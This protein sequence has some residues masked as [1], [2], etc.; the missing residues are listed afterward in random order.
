MSTPHRSEDIAQA[1]LL[2]RYLAELWGGHPRYVK[3]E[4]MPDLEEKM[5]RGMGVMREFVAAMRRES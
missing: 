3:I 1:A 2:D 5:A 4:G